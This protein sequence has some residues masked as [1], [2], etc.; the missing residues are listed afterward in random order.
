MHTEAEADMH[1]E[2]VDRIRADWKKWGMVQGA[3]RCYS[4]AIITKRMW[5]S[6]EQLMNAMG[7]A[8]NDKAGLVKAPEV[9]R[10]CKKL[11]PI[12]K[13][14]FVKDSSEETAD[15]LEGDKC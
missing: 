10:M 12:E 15:S 3:T 8:L 2:E 13:G 9:Y 4:T 11:C 1:T 14:V 6:S 5:R 7:G